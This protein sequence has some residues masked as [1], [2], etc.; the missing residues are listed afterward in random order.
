[1]GRRVLVF[2][3]LLATVVFALHIHIE[4]RIRNNNIVN[5]YGWY[6]VISSDILNSFEEETGIRVVYDVFDNND[7]LE[8]KLLATN[9][10]YDVVFPSFIPYASRQLRIGVYTKLDRNLIPNLKNIEGIVT[11]KYEQAEGS[12][13]YL[14]PIFWGTTG[15]IYEESVI[16]EVFPG[17]S[18]DSYDVLFEPEKLEK[19]KKYGVSFPEECVDIFPQARIYWQIQTPYKSVDIF[20]AYKKKFQALRKHIKKFSSSTVINDLISGEICMAVCSSDNAWRA[21]R[22]AKKFGRVVKYAIT[23]GTGILWVDCVGIPG[24]AP[25]RE[26]AHKFINYIL[27]P[28]IAAKITNGSGILANV[29]GAVK[30]YS[31]EIVADPMICSL[32]DEVLSG[33]LLGDPVTSEDD[34]KYERFA[35]RTWSQIIM[36]AFDDSQNGEKG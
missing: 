7:I 24:G 19:L 31:E 1:M 17:K 3:L 12:V 18:I 34:L 35:S 10:G 23:K 21:I 16:S 27:R 14:V 29:Q 8:A 33:L 28:D 15:I 22:A 36:D 6:G 2:G 32:D 11:Q 30:F 26:N 9:S 5:V 25:H 4:R 20:S 13:E